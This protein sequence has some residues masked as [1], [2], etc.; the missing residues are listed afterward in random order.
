M[1][2]L[3]LAGDRSDLE[4]I[5]HALV[6]EAT[7]RAAIEALAD[8]GHPAAGTLLA[9]LATEGQ[10][11]SPLAARAL[12]KLAGDAGKREADCL[13][14]R[15]EAQLSLLASLPEQPSRILRGQTFDSVGP[16]SSLEALW[17]AAVT[18]QAARE[19]PWLLRLRREVPCGFF[20]G[21]MLDHM[22][23]AD[24]PWSS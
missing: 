3:G 2:V 4:A 7:R 14:Q 17:T 5:A 1:R 8:L 9:R 15:I 21:E 16:H 23:P 12:T 13:S 6:P 24:G 18:Q 20:S 19:Q 11:F 10:P 22:T